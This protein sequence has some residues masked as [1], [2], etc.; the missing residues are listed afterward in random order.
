MW[1]QPRQSTWWELANTSWE[2][3]DWQKNFRM[4]RTSFL[5]LCDILRP[6]L[7]RQHTRYR[8]PVPVDLRVAICLW[9]LATNLEYSSIS[10]LF[11]VGIS[12]ACSVTQQVVLAINRVMKTLYIKTP[13]E[14][15]LMVIVQGF[16]DRWRLPQV[17]GA[18]DG[19]H[20]GIIAPAQDP[21]DYYNRKK[22]HS[23][24]LQGVVDDRMKFWDINVGWPGKVHAAR[25]LVN[26]SLYSRSEN[27]TLFPGWTE[28]L[29]D[30]DV[31]LHVVGDA[32]YP[33]L[34][35]LLKPFP[36]GSGLTQA[37]VHFN[38]QLS[39]ARMTVERAFGRLKGRWR[40]LL[41]RCD[42]HISFVSHIISACCVLHNYCETAN[43]EWEDEEAAD[44]VEDF[45]DPEI[46][47]Q[48]NRGRQIRDAIKWHLQTSQR[49]LKCATK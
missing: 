29:N 11:G 2:E 24:I 33:L 47:H 34:P 19:T 21:T 1:A 23:V 10:Q 5:R 13:S 6:Q 20:I 37:Q 8:R 9:R 14:A 3:K 26:S 40:C 36:E 16:R 41:Q 46:G 48:A 25:V 27:G 42:A 43:E 38:Y 15:E 49:L 35:W 30:V 18:I 32:A 17:A 22:F 12:T 28:R 31:P 39:Q 45:A 44:D 7:T 4:T